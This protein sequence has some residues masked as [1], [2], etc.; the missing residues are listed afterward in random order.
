[1][2]KIIEVKTPNCQRCKMFEPTLEKLVQE[3]NCEL[4]VKVFGES[5]DVIDLVNKYSIRSAPTFIVIKED[6]EEIAKPETL[7]EVLK[8]L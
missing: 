4:E 5:D 6:K 8:S 2:I 1:M 7:E 3:Y